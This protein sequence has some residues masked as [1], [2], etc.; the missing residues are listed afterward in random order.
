MMVVSERADVNRRRRPQYMA[1]ERRLTWQPQPEAVH[2]HALPEAVLASALSTASMR[3][4]A[5]AL[6]GRT[7]FPPTAM[8]SR[9]LQPAD[10]LPLLPSPPPH[11]P[12]PPPAPAP[13]L[14]LRAPMHDSGATGEP[15]RPGDVGFVRAGIFHRL[16][17]VTLP[18]AHVAHR[19]LGLP[20]GFE[21][22]QLSVLP[23]AVPPAALDALVPRGESVQKRLAAEQ[24]PTG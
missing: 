13:P 18:R 8:T 2:D 10:S 4:P 5:R 12:E 22:L 14:G 3:V 16:F 11:P 17:N 23:L 9:T 21:P 15:V 7:P 19:A 20:H 24:A 1:A 6:P